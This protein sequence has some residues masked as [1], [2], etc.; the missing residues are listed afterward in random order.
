MV[1]RPGIRR[2]RTITI[3]LNTLFTL[4]NY[5]SPNIPNIPV[6]LQRW[7]A[8]GEHVTATVSD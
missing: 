6:K 8:R 4:Q 1:F 3:V 5:R 7:K 2:I